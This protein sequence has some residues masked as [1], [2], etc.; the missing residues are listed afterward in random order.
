MSIVQR[1]RKKVQSK[2]KPAPVSW[3]DRIELD[4]SAWPDF[5]ALCDVPIELGP[6]APEVVDEE[7]RY[8][9]GIV[10]DGFAGDFTGEPAM[11]PGQWL[12]LRIAAHQARSREPGDVEDLVATAVNDVLSAML[13]FETGSVRELLSRD[14]CRFKGIDL[15]AISLP[16]SRESHAADL[17]DEQAAPYLALGGSLARLVAAAILAVGDRIEATRARTLRDYH[18]SEAD[19]EAAFYAAWEAV[20]GE[21]PDL[22]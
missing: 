6:V 1:P 15:G 21:S 10:R 22:S 3:E 8:Y 11:A 12:R 13:F 19:T 18:Q 2:P 7:E 17:L 20:C 4:P 9:A 16:G 5:D 14:G